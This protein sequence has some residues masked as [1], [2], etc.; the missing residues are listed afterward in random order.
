ML[1]GRYLRIYLIILLQQIL[2]SGRG[3]RKFLTHEVLLTVMDQV[4]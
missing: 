1:F 2:C 3:L 4:V